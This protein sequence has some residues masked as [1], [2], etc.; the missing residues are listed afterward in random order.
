[1][2]VIVMLS[3]TLLTAHEDGVLQPFEL[4]QHRFISDY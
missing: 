1:M 3:F 4:D 2:F